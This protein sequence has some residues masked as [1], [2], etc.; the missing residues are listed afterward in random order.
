VSG[1]MSLIEATMRADAEAVRVIGHNIANSQV[2]GYRRQIPVSGISSTFAAATDEAS[3]QMQAADMMAPTTHIETDLRAGALKSTGRALDVALE[4]SG[5]FVLQGAAGSL[6]TRRGDM[7]VSAEGTLIAATGEPVLG[8]QGAIDIGTG[9][10][11]I[12]AD[13][14]VRVNDEIIDRLR[15]VQVTNEA[16]LEYLGNGLFSASDDAGVVIQEQALLRQG[17]LEA[18]NIS[19][20]GEMVQMMEAMRRFESAQRFARGYDQLMEKAISELGKVG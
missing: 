16:G 19:P 12:A 4:G 10:P 7:Q 1:T 2:A 13:G 14:T 18:S 17:F 20:V 3:L 6:L 11:V 5:F 15:V 9:T 8:E